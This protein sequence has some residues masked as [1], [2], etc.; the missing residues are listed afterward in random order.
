MLK[1]NLNP[2]ATEQIVTKQDV[3]GRDL[4]FEVVVEGKPVLWFPIWHFVPPEP[5]DRGLQVTRFQ[6]LNVAD[7]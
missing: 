6:A 5:V 3:F 2:F 7:V 4:V 1:I